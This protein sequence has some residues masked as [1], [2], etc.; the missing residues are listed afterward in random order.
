MNY[1]GGGEVEEEEDFPSNCDSV[2]FSL[3]APSGHMITIHSVFLVVVGWLLQQE[4]EE[5]NGKAN[6]TQR[7]MKKNYG[8]ET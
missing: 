8:S 1:R 3:V 7:V 4:E 2:V 6:L 5:R